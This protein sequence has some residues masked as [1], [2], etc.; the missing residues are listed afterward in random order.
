MKQKQNIIDVEIKMLIDNQKASIRFYTIFTFILWMVGISVV[1]FV[2]TNK[3]INNNF[4]IVLQTSAGLI[5]A[6]SCVPLKEIISKREKVS[7]YRV[8]S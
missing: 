5:G 6:L 4:Q 1:I 7:A 8:C 3:A 2:Y